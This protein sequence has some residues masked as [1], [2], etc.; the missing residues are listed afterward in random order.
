[1]PRLRVDCVCGFGICMFCGVNSVDLGFLM[2]CFACCLGV[3][4]CLL[5]C[6]LLIGWFGL[7]AIAAWGCCL[8]HVVGFASG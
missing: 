1:M 7:F 8:L 5:V 4:A 3:F 2:I 6:L